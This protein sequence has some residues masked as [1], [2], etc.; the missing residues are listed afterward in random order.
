[1]VRIRIF[2]DNSLRTVKSR[3]LEVSFVI[4]D[5]KR[6]MCKRD[7]GLLSDRFLIGTRRPLSYRV[8]FFVAPT[9]YRTYR[10]S[11]VSTLGRRT[12]SQPRER[13]R[14]SRTVS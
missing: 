2:R 7:K 1:M 5:K 3:T 10:G 12:Q 4:K 11:L 9:L 14:G 13:R 6:E 8:R